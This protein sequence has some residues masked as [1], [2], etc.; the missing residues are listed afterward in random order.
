MFLF[1][2]RWKNM[3]TQDLMIECAKLSLD[4]IE[5]TW[6][7]NKYSMRPLCEEADWNS[8]D[9]ESKI[10]ITTEKYL[11]CLIFITL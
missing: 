3:E 8:E 1:S 11:L 2:F 6:E 10:L 4:L 5:G 9:L 7:E